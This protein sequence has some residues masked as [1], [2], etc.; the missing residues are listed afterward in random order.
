[1]KEKIPL[2]SNYREFGI[3]CRRSNIKITN[4]FL[5]TIKENRQDS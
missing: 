4:Y 5:M 3:T 1:M 2:I